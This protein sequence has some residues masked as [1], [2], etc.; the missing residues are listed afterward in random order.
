MSIALAM[1]VG[2]AWYSVDANDAIRL[3]VEGMTTTTAHSL[4][5]SRLHRHFGQIDD[6]LSRWT[7]VYDE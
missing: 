2:S 7:M 1:G 4:L 3:S 5:V 6:A